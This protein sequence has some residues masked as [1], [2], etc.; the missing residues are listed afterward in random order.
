MLTRSRTDFEVDGSQ[1]PIPRL[2]LIPGSKSQVLR[3]SIPESLWTLERHP[4]T[5]LVTAPISTTSRS[6]PI[7]PPVHH[8]LKAWRFPRLQCDGDVCSAFGVGFARI[9]LVAASCRFLPVIY[10]TFSQREESSSSNAKQLAEAALNALSLTKSIVNNKC[11]FA[12][13]ASVRVLSI[14]LDV[15]TSCSDELMH[16]HLN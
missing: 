2:D 13:L 3:M 7:R 4:V 10:A 14:L 15:V 6:C 12:T 9:G 16:P 8:R 11:E 5:K 1:L